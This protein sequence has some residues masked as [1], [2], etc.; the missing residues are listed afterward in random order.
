[1]RCLRK[2]NL[3]EK[4][5]RTYSR[6]CVLYMSNI[7]Y[8]GRKCQWGNFKAGYKLPLLVYHM[9]GKESLVPFLKC[10]KA[11]KNLSSTETSLQ[12]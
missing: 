10:E 6:W 1:M 7:E 3:D 11:S 12:D 8:A 9:L 2:F 4:A 5:T